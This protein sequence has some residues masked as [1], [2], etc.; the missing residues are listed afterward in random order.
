ME[1]YK[2][3]KRY[4]TDMNLSQEELAEKIYVT[5]QTISNW[6]NDK[7]YPDI[8]SL[9][10]LSS[11]FHISLDQLIKGDITTMKEAIQKFN[12]DGA[13]FT[14]LLILTVIAAVPLAVFL[15]YCGYI[16]WGILFLI[17]IYY[18]LRVEK[19]KKEN[20]IMT[21]KEIVAFTEGKQLDEIEKAQEKGKRPYQQLLSA[22]LSA[23]IGF[24]ISMFLFG[25]SNPIFF[26][27]ST[28]LPIKIS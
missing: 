15:G 11:T 25:C 26:N 18:A 6:E 7:S 27:P 10:L 12:R 24:I 14:V 8:H 21:Y 23:T 2:Q 16:V 3:I 28:F 9:L 5:R 22:L 20:D 4:R 13:I 17:M 19:F 1:L